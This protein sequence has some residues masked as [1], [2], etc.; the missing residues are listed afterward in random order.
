ML[1]FYKWHSDAAHGWLEVPA[2]DCLDVGLDIKT[3]SQYSYFDKRTLYLEEDSDAG[4]FIE[5]YAAH[6]NGGAPTMV[7]MAQAPGESFIRSLP[8]L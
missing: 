3:I 4:K 2:H 1:T 6:H 7:E 8:R 5:A